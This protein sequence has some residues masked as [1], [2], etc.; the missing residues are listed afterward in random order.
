MYIYAVD[1]NRECRVI[2]AFTMGWECRYEPWNVEMA[3]CI[4]DEC[5]CTSKS[6]RVTDVSSTDSRLLPNVR[7][8]L[9][10]REWRNRTAKLSTYSYLVS[11]L[12]VHGAEPVP[13]IRRNPEPYLMKP[14]DIYT[15]TNL[16]LKSTISVP[17]GSKRTIFKAI[18]RF[19]LD[20][21]KR[22]PSD[23]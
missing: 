21:K 11:R 16:L 1:I 14:I 18:L 17:Y 10:S 2:K 13:L 23:P 3:P 15:I 20:K 19:F 22:I 12:R 5:V 6:D 9:F 4:G 7:W 8:E